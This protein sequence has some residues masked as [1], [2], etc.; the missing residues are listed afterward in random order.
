MN[1]PF[2]FM[3]LEEWKEL[4]AKGQAP[5]DVILPKG[6][7]IEVRKEEDVSR[8]IT[9]VISCNDRD[10]EHDKVEATGA[11]LENYV[12]NPVVLWAH[13]YRD[14]PIARAPKT[15]IEAD[16]ILSEPEFIG[17]ETYPFA[18]MIEK[19]VRGSFLNAASIGFRP[20]VYQINQDEHGYDFNEWE[21]LEYS[22]VPVPMQPGALV[23]ARSAG[24]DLGPLKAWAEKVLDEF[25]GSEERVLIDT[26]WLK[27]VNE[28]LRVVNNERR[29]LLMP[30]GF[31]F[32]EDGTLVLPKDV[33]QLEL[34]VANTEGVSEKQLFTV[35]ELLAAAKR[36]HADPA[37]DGRNKDHEEEDVLEDGDDILAGIEPE[38]EDGDLVDLSAE[39]V[40]ALVGEAVGAEMNSRMTE[41]TG[42]LD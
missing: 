41:W 30:E 28:T 14:V 10:R 25:G 40:A 35:D 27:K 18:A 26:D 38:D 8:P 21:L 3:R 4:D 39:D 34:Q 17:A 42:R 11:R 6:Y 32:H 37:I 19:L 1:P 16:R 7:L 31:E 9:I 20:M 2:P 12:K 36:G 15:W 5:K 24:I 13:G 29:S 22:I 23:V 33:K